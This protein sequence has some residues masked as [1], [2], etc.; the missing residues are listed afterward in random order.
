MR[1]AIVLLL[2][3][4]SCSEVPA[5]PAAPPD[6]FSGRATLVGDLAAAES[7]ALMVSV[8][9][10]GSKMPLMTYRVGMDSPEVSRVDGEVHFDFLLD[11]TTSMIPGSVPEDLPLELEVRFDEDGIVETKEGDVTARVP[12]ELGDDDLELTLSRD[13]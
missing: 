3:T 5:E 2:F 12:V 10:P 4:A 9:T 11:P 6:G 1:I 13:P 7:G 8:Y